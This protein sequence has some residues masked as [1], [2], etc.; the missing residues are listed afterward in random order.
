MTKTVSIRMDE[1]LLRALDEQGGK[2]ARSEVLREAVEVWLAQKRLNAKVERHR[3]GYGRWPE[4]TDEFA[5]LHA[6]QVWPAAH[7]KGG[8]RG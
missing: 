3:D 5:A 8:R 6:A 4:Q 7:G 1:A 2:R